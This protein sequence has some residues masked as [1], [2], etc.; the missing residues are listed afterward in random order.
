MC[1][2]LASPFFPLQYFEGI[3]PLCYH[4]EIC[5]QLSCHCLEGNQ[6]LLSKFW[7]SFFSSILTKD[8]SAWQIQSQIQSKMRRLY[9]L[10]HVSASSSTWGVLTFLSAH[11]TVNC[12][13]PMIKGN[14]NRKKMQCRYCE[15]QLTFLL[16][17][18]L[19]LYCFCGSILTSF[20]A[21][22]GSVGLC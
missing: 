17:L 13:L 12:A 11:L 20:L 8:L 10:E 21:A 4:R 6:P 2:I 1:E 5:C 19:T 3:I 22:L 14:E 16:K 9:L 7:A 18:L 15:T